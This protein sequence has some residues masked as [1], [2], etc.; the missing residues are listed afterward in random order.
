MLKDAL[1]EIKTPLPGPKAGALI[2]RRGEALP[3]AIRSVY[4]LVI[5]RGEGAMLED[6]DGNIFLDWVGGVG[7]LNIGYS[8]TEV[9][10]AV[11]EQAGRY[12]HGM[13]N[14]LT[15]EGYVAL[16]EKLNRIVPVREKNGGPCS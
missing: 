4:P 6:P 1:P 10:E 15:H 13:A 7:V 5:S 14:I 16:A 9:V 8:Q 2:A 11:R 3:A 12:F